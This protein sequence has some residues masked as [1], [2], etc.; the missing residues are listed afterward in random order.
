MHLPTTDFFFF[1]FFLSSTSLIL[2]LANASNSAFDPLV[3]ITST[4]TSTTTTTALSAEATNPT[5]LPQNTETA[6]SPLIPHDQKHDPK[7]KY[8][9]NHNDALPTPGPN[10]TIDMYNSGRLELR[11]QGGVGGGIGPPAPSVQTQVP[12]IYT[13]NG[14]VYTQTFA[15]VDSQGPAPQVGTIGL[16]TLTGTVGAVRAPTGK[17]AAAAVVRVRADLGF[18]GLGMT[19][20]LIWA[21]LSL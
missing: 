10:A 3:G 11:Q 2:K 8:N 16:G 20:S 5:P 19:G 9:Y 21:G 4:S 6:S 15:A 1:F 18:W 17:S 13:F 14:V 7:H 12:P